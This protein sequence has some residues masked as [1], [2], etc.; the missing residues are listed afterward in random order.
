MMLGTKSNGAGPSIKRLLGVYFQAEM[1][2]VLPLKFSWI[3]EGQLSGLV[4][5]LFCWF[6]LSC[7][8]PHSDQNSMLLFSILCNLK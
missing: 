4:K 3:N 5:L 2:L 8:K 6:I 7:N 1:L